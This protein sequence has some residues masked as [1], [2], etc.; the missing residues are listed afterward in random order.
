MGRPRTTRASHNGASMGTRAT[1]FAL[2]L[3]A[4]APQPPRDVS[5][6][7][8]LVRPSD[9][10]ATVHAGCARCSWGES[11]REAAALRVSIDGAYSQ[12]LLLAR[13]AVPA[14]YPMTIGS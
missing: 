7:F 6:T 12:H 8:D 2:V 4:A 9:V 14:D 13:G 10:V 3:L 11:G 1:V 5:K